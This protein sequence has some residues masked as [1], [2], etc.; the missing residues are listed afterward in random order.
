MPP[1]LKHHSAPPSFSRQANCISKKKHMFNL[2]SI[3]SE[4]L[5]T[6]AGLC[7]EKSRKP[8]PP[9]P[10]SSPQDILVDLSD[11]YSAV[12]KKQVRNGCFITCKAYKAIIDSQSIIF[13]RL[14]QI[15]QFWTFISNSKRKVE[16]QLHKNIQKLVMRGI[17]PKH[18]SRMWQRMCGVQMRPANFMSYTDILQLPKKMDVVAQIGLDVTRTFPD[19]ADQPYIDSL[20]RVLTAHSL[21]N[22]KLGYWQSMNFVAG[23][24]LVF[25]EEEEAF[26]ML[27]YIVEELLHDYFIPC[28]AGFKADVELFER[29]V[30]ERLPELYKH[31]QDIHLSFGILT[32]PWFLCLFVNTFPTETTYLIWDNIMMEG[33]VVF[34][35]IGLAILTMYASEL[36]QYED[37]AEVIAHIRKS[38]LS[39]YEPA[40]LRKHWYTLDKAK[41]DREGR[42]IRKRMDMEAK[43]MITIKQYGELEL[44]THFESKEIFKLWN[45]YNQIVPSSE[46]L[47]L[48]PFAQLVR[49]ALSEWH[50]D[51]KVIE[52]LFQIADAGQDGIVDFAEL[53]KLLSV[54][55]R[56]TPKE[57]L[58][59]NFR[60]FDTNGKGWIDKYDIYRMLQSVYSVFR[61]D[62]RFH[63]LLRSFVE[64]IFDYTSTDTLTKTDFE[65]V[66][67]IQSQILATF[68]TRNP[69]V[70]FTPEHT[71]FYWMFMTRPNKDKEMVPIVP[72]QQTNERQA[73]VHFPS[74]TISQHAA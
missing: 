15:D 3:K 67:W 59:L 49:G 37:Q 50:A 55:T 19:F 44:S 32:S 5:D 60:L 56:G 26:W 40:L 23:T 33:K 52:R 8:S 28:M 25:M 72:E 41:L 63:D 14:S 53:L 58:S 54:M 38:T 34:F 65:Y 10:P 45:Q 35:E 64:S 30:A 48:E 47:T 39:I 29:L 61:R 73:K 31:L 7:L 62:K 6:S 57:V 46:G 68:K 27:V 42:R 2:L 36:F 9:S 20:S 69:K 51:S 12:A 4:L 11:I 24:L 16:T 22:P 70:K 74:I 71:Y 21:R 18:R 13:D 66:V 17:P 43:T 1:A